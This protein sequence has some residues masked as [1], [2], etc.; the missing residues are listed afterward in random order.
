MVEACAGE[1]NIKVR[2][3]TEKIVVRCLTGF[4]ARFEAVKPLIYRMK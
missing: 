4:I 1:V 2:Q 3:P